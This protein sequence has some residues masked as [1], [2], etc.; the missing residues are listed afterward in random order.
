MT[1]PSRQWLRVVMIPVA[2]SVVLAGLPGMASAESDATSSRRRAAEE[3]REAL[4]AYQRALEDELAQA[5]RWLEGTKEKAEKEW[6]PEARE[7]L[8]EQR[9][10]ARRDLER[11]TEEAQRAWESIRA[12]MDRLVDD[13]KR[14]HS[15][16]PQGAAAPRTSLH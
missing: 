16:P 4:S 11:L 1:R 10:R 9:D 3:T 15:E 6:A 8:R 5:E 2:A 14:E 13:V 12:R 7:K